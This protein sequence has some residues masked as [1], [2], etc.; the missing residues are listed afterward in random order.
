MDFNSK[1]MNYIF[2]VEYFK[3]IHLIEKNKKDKEDNKKTLE[4]RNK[5]IKEYSFPN[6]TPIESYKELQ[7]YNDFSLF[8]L[9]PGLLIGIG[10]P[11]DLAVTGAIKTGFSFGFS[12]L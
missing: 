4:N 1:N 11:H 12:T 10:N 9:Y 7:G 8:T 5:E 2:N 3:D 6:I